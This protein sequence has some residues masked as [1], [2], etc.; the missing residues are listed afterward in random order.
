MTDEKKTDGGPAY[1]IDCGAHGECIHGLTVRDWFDGMALQGTCANSQIA[2]DF[3]D[4]GIPDS[5]TSRLIA[6]ISLEIS[7]AML[8]ERNKKEE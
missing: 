5:I 6:Q 7:D 3:A 2:K 1:P 8:A 4:K